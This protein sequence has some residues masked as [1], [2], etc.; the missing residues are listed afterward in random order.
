M[1]GN[2][3]TP[4][5]PLIAYT[6]E[7]AKKIDGSWEHLAAVMGFN[8]KEIIDIFYNNSTCKAIILG[9]GAGRDANGGN[10]GLPNKGS[11]RITTSKTFLDL[12]NIDQFKAALAM[13]HPPKYEDIEQTY[14][15]DFPNIITLWDGYRLITTV[16]AMFPATQTRPEFDLDPYDAM[17]AFFPL[18]TFHSKRHTALHAKKS[19][20][21]KSFDDKCSIREK[22]SAKGFPACGPSGVGNLADI[23]YGP[24]KID[25][26][27]TSYHF[28]SFTSQRRRLVAALRGE[29]S[30]FATGN[31]IRK[32][33]RTSA[34]Q[35]PF[36]A[37]EAMNPTEVAHLTFS[38]V[39]DEDSGFLKKCLLYEP[40]DM[41]T[42][43]GLSDI[44]VTQ[45]VSI[46]IAGQFEDETVELELR[47]AHIQEFV[48][49]ELGTLI[50]YPG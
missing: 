26:A 29:G 47:N 31:Q 33:T 41:L 15:G 28:G 10:W 45:A 42:N 1:A 20:G 6:H 24:Q 48:D 8:T 3:N 35:G 39:D 25:T 19:V 44:E 46:A 21:Q 11:G 14:R 37:P 49:V 27:I 9:Y 32:F 36:A 12:L 5:H 34:K 23:S 18:K 2:K 16:P 50:H 13:V 17:H 22:D 30:A 38:I 43:P 7:E 4:F 40:V